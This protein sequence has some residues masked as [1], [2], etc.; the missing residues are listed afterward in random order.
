MNLLTQSSLVKGTLTTALTKAHF[1]TTEAGFKGHSDNYKKAPFVELYF[2][3][4]QQQLALG[5]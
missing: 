3:L 2:P 5:A 1:Q 4:Y